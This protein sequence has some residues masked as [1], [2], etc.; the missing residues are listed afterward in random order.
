MILTLNT[1]TEQGEFIDYLLR[2]GCTVTRLDAERFEVCVT[3]PDTVNDEEAS[4]I[5]WCG[6]WTARRSA[7][8]RLV[9]ATA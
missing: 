5:E 2:L 7:P 8:V 6:S 3:Y 4:L 1:G 9:P